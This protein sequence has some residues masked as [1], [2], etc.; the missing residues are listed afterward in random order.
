M[1]NRVIAWTSGPQ[2]AQRGVATLA[3]GV[4]L[5]VLITLVSLYG[6]RVTLLEQRVSANDYRSREAYGAAQAGLS[7]GIELVK[8]NEGRLRS[9]DTNGWLVSTNAGWT[10]GTIS[11][12]CTSPPSGSIEEAACNS[13]LSGDIRTYAI[14]ASGTKTA[15]GPT[16]SLTYVSAD[17]PASASGTFADC[18]GA[19]CRAQIALILCEFENV[20]DPCED[21]GGTSSKYAVL[22]LARGESADGTGQAQMREMLAPLDFF[23]GNALPPLMASTNVSISGTLDVVVNPN[24]AYN[25]LSGT[26][27]GVP[28]SGWSNGDLVL[29]GDASFCYPDEYFQNSQSQPSDL[30]SMA[31]CDS[32]LSNQPCQVDV[33]TSGGAL[34]PMP[35]CD[36]CDC[37]SSGNEAL[38]TS[39]AS[40]YFEGIDVVDVDGNSGPTPDATN[41]PSDVFQYI[42][43]VDHEDYELIKFSSDT[44]L[45]PD[46]SS[47]DS[48]STGLYWITGDC[49]ISGTAGSP[50]GPLLLV[51]EG[52]FQMQGGGAFFGLV[53]AFSAPGSGINGGAS[54]KLTGG[55]QFYGTVVS[56]HQ[57]T[58]GGGTYDLIYSQCMFDRIGN[59]DK[60]KHLGP[61]PG[62]WADHI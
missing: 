52:D 7:Y 37:P 2:R 22:V 29:S 27:Q 14:P 17:W 39:T 42:F 61:V 25:T 60:F 5:L 55:P 49:S 38:T 10:D 30:T 56:D 58:F 28:I 20:G 18:P 12:D 43:G 11:I 16:D 31:T 6:M 40:N 44:Q 24:G 53:F 4:I 47:I 21:A 51:T 50:T 13:G 34:C 26:G 45:L 54:V 15:P 41:F 8:G 32:S 35:V 1:S 46:C 48:S 33:T 57:V 3:I 36:D 62:S 59:D 19:G 9:T 23:P